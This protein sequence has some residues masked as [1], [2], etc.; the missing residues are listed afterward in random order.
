[1]GSLS[2]TKMESR[3]TV[4]DRRMRPS[5]AGSACA[6]CRGAKWWP[7]CS[8][9]PCSVIWGSRWRP[10]GR[11]LLTY[12]WQ[13]NVVYLAASVAIYVLSLLLGAT[14]WHRIVWSMDRRVPYR[15][16]VKFF[17]QS[18][19][20]KR[21]PGLV[22]YALGRIYLYEREAVAKTTVT[23][24]LALE[25]VSVIAGGVFV[26]LLTIWGSDSILV[27]LDLANLAAGWR[28]WALLPLAGLVLVIVWPQSLYRAA[29]WVLARRGH[30]PLGGQA[31]RRGLMEWSLLQ[32]GGWLTGG[33]F[34]YF[35]AA[36]V[37]PGLGW[38]HLVE[39]ITSWTGAGLA[40]YVTLIVPLG[41]GLKELTLAYL[42][43]SFLPWPIAVLISLL[44]RIC[45]IIGDC[46]G[47]LVASRL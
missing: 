15:K 9:L 25:M 23:M 14:A 22:W 29:N 8:P 38:P 5:L 45:S 2:T 36:G 37:Y 1:M 26:F 40:A 30:A 13:I 32:V 39:T 19:V 11:S 12:D 27:R 47:L 3:S 34:L 46:V 18:N 41:L 20:A 17:L 16:G 10:T 21:L 43:S 31:S 6:L 33:L 44:G 42:L 7:G 4:S 35:L 28:W 24:A